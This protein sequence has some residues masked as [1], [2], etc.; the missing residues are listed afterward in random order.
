[1][2]ESEDVGDR[3][4]GLRAGEICRLPKATKGQVLVMGDDGW[5]AGEA[6]AG[7]AHQ[8]VTAE[9]TDDIETT[10]TAYVD[11]PDMEVTITTSGGKVL[12]LFNSLIDGYTTWALIYA[13]I[14]RDAVVVGGG[15]AYAETI[16]VTMAVIAIDTPVAGTYTYKV[17]WHTSSGDTIKNFGSNADQTRRLIAIELL[18]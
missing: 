5:E 18:S 6:A 7:A 12:L 14:I 10:S 4:V 11:M 9:G 13:R 8:V 3:R 16:A 17:Q 15:A 1:M 2:P